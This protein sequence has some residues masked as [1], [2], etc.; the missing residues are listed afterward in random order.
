MYIKIKKTMS[1]HKLRDND[2]KKKFSISLNDKLNGILEDYMTKNGMS[3]KSKYI[4]N[5][6]KKDL[7]NRGEKFNIDF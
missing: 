2:K 6:V 5:L 1:R 4:E 3:N 7:E